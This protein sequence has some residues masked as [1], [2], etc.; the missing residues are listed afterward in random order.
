MFQD[1][2]EQIQEAIL[3][4]R[5][6]PGEKL[7][8]ERELKESFNISRGTLREALR[9]LEQKGLI[10][11][12]L[13]VRG[14]AIVKK[15]STTPMLETLSLMVRRKEIPFEN[16]Q[17]FRSSVESDIASLAAQRGTPKDFKELAAILEEARGH[18]EGRYDWD[19]FIHADGRFHQQLA[20]MARNQLF[21]L[22]QK[23]VH[24]NIHEYF[25]SYLSRKPEI[26]EENL[27]DLDA[28]FHA[29]K[30]GDSSRAARLMA[31]HVV[32]FDLHMARQ[33]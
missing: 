19:A 11:I 12:R 16:L 8:S 1:V 33:S 10:E 27:K 2:V 3:D 30:A 21:S 31:T 17:E 26:L 14:G 4:G 25:A 32:K 24:E 7:P 6:S 18:L 9:V 23:A 15:A 28:I 29:V 13:G 20:K 22:V 5:L